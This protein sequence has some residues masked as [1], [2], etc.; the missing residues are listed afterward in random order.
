M[1]RPIF[2]I[3]VKWIV[4]QCRYF[5]YFL[6]SEVDACNFLTFEF[7]LNV[8]VDRFSSLSKLN[9]LICHISVGL[10]IIHDVIGVVLYAVVF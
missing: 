3:C 5:I 7:T 8:L 2:H 4:N 6:Y 1:A 10:C 9:I